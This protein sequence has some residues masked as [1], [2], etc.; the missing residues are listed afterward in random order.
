M[1]DASWSGVH[2]VNIQ[3]AYLDLGSYLTVPVQEQ[4]KESVES[5]YG[6]LELMWGINAKDSDF[7]CA[8]LSSDD[9]SSIT[10]D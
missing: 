1:T 4:A 10:S 3:D 2:T 6:I 8:E 9:S 5:Y 7:S